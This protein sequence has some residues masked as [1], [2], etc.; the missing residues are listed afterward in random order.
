MYKR[1]I[2]A[3]FANVT[4]SDVTS[5]SLNVLRRET[6]PNHVSASTSTFCV[7]PVETRYF[8]N[9]VSN[10][11]TGSRCKNG[12]KPHETAPMLPTN[13]V[14]AS[15]IMFSCISSRNEVFLQT[16]SFPTFLPVIKQHMS[17]LLLKHPFPSSF[18]VAKC[19]L[20]IFAVLPKTSS[21]SRY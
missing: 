19:A 21:F 16:T 1:Q 8:Q 14:S 7:F 5:S 9:I 12:F 3:N 6:P 13:H 11:F 20:C 18:H 10:I 2:K 4:I 17:R 15:K